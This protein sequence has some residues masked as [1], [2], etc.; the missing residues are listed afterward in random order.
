MPSSGPRSLVGAAS[1][2]LVSERTAPSSGTVAWGVQLG[3][4]GPCHGLPVLPRR[5]RGLR[6]CGR[7]LVRPSQ[8]TRLLCFQPHPGS[9]HAGK[10]GTVLRGPGPQRVSGLTPTALPVNPPCIHPHRE[11]GA[12]RAPFFLEPLHLCSSLLRPVGPRTPFLQVSCQRSS[13]TPW[14]LLFCLGPLPIPQR[15][16]CQEGAGLGPCDPSCTLSAQAWGAQGHSRSSPLTLSSG[17]L[18]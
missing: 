15:L 13:P 7:E 5:P 16:R 6:P 3:R 12:Q 14:S 9:A 2:A 11:P 8:G 17:R 4:R 10:T 1:L 18:S